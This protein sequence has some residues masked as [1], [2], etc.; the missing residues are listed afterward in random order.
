[1]IATGSFFHI[2]PST[3]HP[4]P[5]PLSHAWMVP[6]GTIN[7]FVGLAGV[8]DPAEV[9]P[10]QLHDPYAPGQLLTA[11]LPLSGEAYI[12]E[13]SAL[14]DDADSAAAAS[15]TGSIIAASVA[16]SITPV[17]NPGDFEDSSILPL[18]DCDSEPDSI[19]DP[20]YQ[21][22]APILMATGDELPN[23]PFTTLLPAKTTAGD[24]EAHRVALEARR[25]KELV[26]RQKLRVE[27]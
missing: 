15:V 7:L 16:D 27:Q 25:K 6:V 8:S 9:R 26:E 24:I 3:Y 18:F 19:E 4:A 23:Y 11:T 12:E 13:E 1:M 5:S 14:E 17:S 20:Q 2:Q 21:H 10:G 22:H